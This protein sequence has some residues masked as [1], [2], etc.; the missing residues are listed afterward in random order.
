M[1]GSPGA[2]GWERIGV[3]VHMHVQR[4]QEDLNVMCAQIPD[5]TVLAHHAMP[6]AAGQYL[7]TAN[8]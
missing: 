5:A 1:H 8:D 4:E 2:G 3:Q 7:T 6:R